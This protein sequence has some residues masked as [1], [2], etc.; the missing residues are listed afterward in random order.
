MVKKL[1]LVSAALILLNQLA[2]ARSHQPKKSVPQPHFD[3]IYHHW[4]DGSDFTWAYDGLKEV[5]P[6][7]VVSKSTT[8]QPR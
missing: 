1:V 5:P 2:S 8:R 4:T 3:T 6:R 7:K